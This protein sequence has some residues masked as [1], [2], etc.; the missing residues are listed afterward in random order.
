M[1]QGGIRSV[2]SHAGTGSSSFKQEY[3]NDIVTYAGGTPASEKTI[4]I[5]ADREV[6]AI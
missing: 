1:K 5:A 3:Q 6:A 4:T 2:G